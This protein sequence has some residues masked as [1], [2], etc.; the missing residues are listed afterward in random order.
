MLVTLPPSEWVEQHTSSPLIDSILQFLPLLAINYTGPIIPAARLPLLG[1][2]QQRNLPG[3][4]HSY[5]A[6]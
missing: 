2:E 5:F 3:R 4:H 1:H 6:I